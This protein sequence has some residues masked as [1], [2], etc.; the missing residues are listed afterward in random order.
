MVISYSRNK[1]LIQKDVRGKLAQLI[2]MEGLNI[3]FFK[4]TGK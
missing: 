3:T 1:R 2:N 4:K